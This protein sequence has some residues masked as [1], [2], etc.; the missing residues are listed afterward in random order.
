M[1]YRYRVSPLLLCVR[2]TRFGS[3][4]PISHSEET[5]VFVSCAETSS[6]RSRLSSS[7]FLLLTS[8]FL[9]AQDSATGSLRGIVLDP[10]GS[11][12]AQA[13]IALVNNANGV[14]YTSTTGAQGEFALELPPGDYSARV[15][16]HGMSPEATPQLHIDVGGMARLE[17]HLKVAGAQEQVTV[18]AAPPAVETQ[19][20]AVSTLL[21]ERAIADFPLN[22]RR[23]SDLALFS[24]GVT[25]DPRS[26]TSATNGDLSFGGLRGYQ[27]SFLVDGSDY[28]N[29]F[30][31][32]ARGAIAPR[33]HFPPKSYRSSASRRIL[34]AP[35]RDAR[36]ARW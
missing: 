12:V 23:F 29:A 22:G 5:H 6:C 11:R 4:E 25:Q 30:F 20:I 34:M 31:A 7:I 17:F 9:V 24:P 36:A 26:L 18:S 32:Q 3:S 14:R 8:C 1:L 19:P 10:S 15:E 33:F 2:L 13:S 28:N 27:N 16:A 35:S 21:D